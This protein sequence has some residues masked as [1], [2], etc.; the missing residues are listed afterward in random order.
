M[1]K[2]LQKIFRVFFE[3]LFI[4]VVFY[5][6]VALCIFLNIWFNN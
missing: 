3:Y 5:A 6:W 1:K 2:K 4:A